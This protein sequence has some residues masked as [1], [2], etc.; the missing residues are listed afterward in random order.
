MHSIFAK[1][2]A[3]VAMLLACA[4]PLSASIQV[5]DKIK[6]YDGVGMPGGIFNVDDLNDGPTNSIEFQTFCVEI[7]EYIGFGTKYAVQS[8]GTTTVQGGNTLQPL[9]AWLYNSFLNG[10]LNN[11]NPTNSYDANALQLALWISIGY[12]HGINSP[13]SDISKYIGQ[14][15]YNMYYPK[16]QAKTWAT[17][18]TNS[19]WSGLG[20]VQIMNLRGVNSDGIYTTNNQDQLIREMPE[21]WSFLVWSV[22]AICAGGLGARRHLQSA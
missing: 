12:T 11:F 14:S 9:T 1:L 22:L 5:G 18:F 16:L 3:A 21:P 17:D 8:I 19:G 15:W 7:T 13:N 4:V 20:G 10:T 2:F 6:L